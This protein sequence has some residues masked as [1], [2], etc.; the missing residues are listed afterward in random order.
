[1]SIAPDAGPVTDKK[2][3]RRDVPSY[4]EP[5]SWYGIALAIVAAAVFVQLVFLQDLAIRLPFLAFYP[6]VLLG[7]FLMGGCKNSG[8]DPAKFTYR[9]CRRSFLR[10]TERR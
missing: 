9:S 6:A 7:L 5:R 3:H 10:F 8:K 1:M 2:G 4:I